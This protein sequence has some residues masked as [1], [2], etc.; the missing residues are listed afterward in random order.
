MADL[1][2][3]NSPQVKLMLEWGEGFKAKDLDRIAKPLHKD[4]RY[5]TYPRSLNKPEQ[6]R[7]EW[8]AHI[9]GIVNLWTD[10]EVDISRYSDPLRRG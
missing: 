1:D 3:S 4:H 7:E 2:N 10:N 8:L 5:I 6:T 9:G